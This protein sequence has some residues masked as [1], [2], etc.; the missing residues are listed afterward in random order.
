MFQTYSG[1][2]IAEPGLASILVNTVNTVGVMGAGFARA[3]REAWPE[4]MPPYA[5][6]CTDGRLRPG[7]LQVVPVPGGPTIINMATKEHWRTPSRLEWV[8]SGLVFL[9]RWLCARALPG[10]RVALPPPGCGHGGLDWARVGRM[11][12]I[13]LEHAS[14]RGVEI[15]LLRAMEPHPGDPIH[16]AGIGSRET[17]PDVLAVMSEAAGH[18]AERGFV[19]R[20]GGARGADSAFHAGARAANGPSEIFLAEQRSGF[21]DGVCDIRE[22]HVRHA[23]SLHPAPDRLSP[24]ARKLMARN[25]PQVC[26][27]DFSQPSDLVIAWTAEG[28]GAGGTGQS[29]RLAKVIGIPALDLGARSYQGI[30][31]LDLADLAVQTVQARRERL[32]LPMPGRAE[33]EPQAQMDLGF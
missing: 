32:G 17:P 12:R 26:G 27:L 19:L 3:V 24:Y 21:P 15:G 30:R 5:A 22:L 20:S 33:P 6:A 18:L 16:Y 9:N 2:S 23:L 10:S 29:L 13:Y 25:V 14:A 4:I 1:R 31:A 8:G 11:A 7:T 28:R